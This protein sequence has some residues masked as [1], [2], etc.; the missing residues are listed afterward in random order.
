VDVAAGVSHRR[1]IRCVTPKLPGAGKVL[2]VA[3]CWLGELVVG[4]VLKRAADL[5]ERVE[6]RNESARSTTEPSAAVLKLML[7]TRRSVPGSVAYLVVDNICD[8]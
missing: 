6:Q 7:D 4:T 1:V 3:V 5:H 8:D 2:G